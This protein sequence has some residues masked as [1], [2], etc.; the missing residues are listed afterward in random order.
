MTKAGDLHALVVA[1]PVPIAHAQGQ[2]ALGPLSYPRFGPASDAVLNYTFAA[3]LLSQEATGDM[4]ASI[5]VERTL[6]TLYGA[7]DYR[8]VLIAASRTAPALA[9]IDALGFP[10]IPATAGAHEFFGDWAGFIS[11]G[12]PRTED[13]DIVELD[14]VLSDEFLALPGEELEPE[15]VEVA[16]FLLDTALEIARYY[17]RPIAHIGTVTSQPEIPSF[18]E[19]VLRSAGFTPAHNEVHLRMPVADLGTDAQ[20][21]ADFHVHCWPDYDIDPWYL[22]DVLELLTIAG[23]D[24]AYGEL[25]V[26]PKHWTAPRLEVARRQMHARG[27]HTIIGAITAH[28]QVVALAEVGRFDH[29]IPQVAEWTL[30]VCARPWRRQ[31]LATAAAMAA[32]AELRQLWP[33]VDTLYA[34]VPAADER[35]RG[36]FRRLGPHSTAAATVAWQRHDFAPPAQPAAEHHDS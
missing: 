12:I 4:A 25:Q 9:E 24:A 7:A 19:P 28:G 2:S 20:I 13:T 29:A 10:R 27:A 6:D 36:L 26:N 21:G 11:I 22:D 15:A 23:A 33:E 32:V 18:F 34:A 3:N 5:T 17:R 30:V 35:I 31:G 8:T 14:L 16:R 1:P